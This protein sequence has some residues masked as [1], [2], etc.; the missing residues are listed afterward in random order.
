MDI[1]LAAPDDFP[2]LS[3]LDT[4]ASKHLDRQKEIR[5]WIERGACWVVEV[6]NDL[7]GYGIMT[8]DL[9]GHPFVELIMVAPHYRRSGIGLAMIG[10]FQDL[11]GGK[12]FTSTNLSNRSMQSLLLK[13]GFRSSGY[14]DNL[15]EGDPE[16]VFFYAGS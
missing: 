10:Y 4:F 8:N 15:D 9:F 6:G 3:K 11:C 7:A 2:A 13:A 12:M 16:L 1:R 14:I 5:S